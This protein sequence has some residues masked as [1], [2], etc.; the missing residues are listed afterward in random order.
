MRLV[1]R[2]LLLSGFALTFSGCGSQPSASDVTNGV[3]E[4]V[5]NDAN[6]V[7]SQV[8]GQGSTFSLQEAVAETP[9]AFWFWAPG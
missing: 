6:D 7:T 8:I 9:V 2:A 4:S 5:P 3:T 1:F